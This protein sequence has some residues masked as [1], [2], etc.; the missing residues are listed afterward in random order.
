MMRRRVFVLSVALVAN[1]CA[2]EQPSRVDSGGFQA[3][4]AAGAATNATPADSTRTLLFLGTS[5]T[6]GLGL[7]PD[8]AYP[9]LIQ[10]KLDSARLAYR[11]VNAGV[12]GETSSGLLRRVDWLLQQKLDVVVI[13]TGANDGLRGVPV[14]AMRENLQQIIARIRAAQPSVKVVLVQMEALPNMGKS[15]TDSFHAS[16]PLLARQNPGVTLI[17][18][19]L[20]GV[21]GE[22]D[23]NQADGVHP[24]EEGERIVATNVWKALKPLLR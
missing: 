15:Y 24:N 8:E 2:R 17:P 6:A 21:A 10:R 13:E 7:D 22:R 5:L 1:A 11:V 12:S 3:S 9:S 18:F 4:P 16:F 23:L 20:E 19:L 14:E